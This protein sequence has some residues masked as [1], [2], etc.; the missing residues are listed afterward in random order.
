MPWS[1]PAGWLALLQ[2]RPLATAV[3]VGVA[4]GALLGW[5]VPVRTPTLPQ[6]GAA[7]WQLP[8][9][10]VASRTDETRFAQ[11][12]AAKIW[13]VAG[14]AAAG[15]KLPAWRLTGIITRP[16]PLA[17][18]LADK[19]T[20]L[21]RV[22]VGDGLPDGGSVREI[23]PQRIVFSRSGCSYQRILYVAPDPA[24]AAGCKPAADSAP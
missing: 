5:A 19:S 13:G 12:R 20:A 16:V 1:D 8:D 9:P 3:A 2:R 24:E 23:H 7:H 21:L 15:D 14:S 17:L 4:L 18:V 11:V 6:T 22:G 10:A